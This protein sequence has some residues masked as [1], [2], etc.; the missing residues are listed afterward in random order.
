ML[1]LDLICANTVKCVQ[2][3]IEGEVV[4]T[5]GDLAPSSPRSAVAPEEEPKSGVRFRG[6]AIPG[7]RSEEVLKELQA[8][9]ARRERESRA[10]PEIVKPTSEQG[11]GGLGVRHL[12]L[13]MA[14]LSIALVSLL[15]VFQSSGSPS[16]EAAASQGKEVRLCH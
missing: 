8:L 3:T 9:Y 13:A 16:V 7:K 11:G 10:R 14:L 4:Q 6:G 12:L 2:T 15:V 5:P 1:T